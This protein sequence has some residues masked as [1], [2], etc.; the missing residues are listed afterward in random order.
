[1]E[2][3]LR[4]ERFDQ[5]LACRGRADQRRESFVRDHRSAAHALRH[6]PHRALRDG[7]GEIALPHGVGIVEGAAP[8]S[9]ADGQRPGRGVAAGERHAAVAPAL[10]GGSDRVEE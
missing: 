5:R 4:G 6:D 2:E 1:M 9:V 8:T 10:E 7:I 3:Q